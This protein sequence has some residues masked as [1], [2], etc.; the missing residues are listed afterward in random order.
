M[1]A[2][3][4]D[5]ADS[6]E[7]DSGQ[8]AMKIAGAVFS[9]SK[10][11]GEKYGAAIV[12]ALVILGL[13]Y[14]WLV[15]L[16]KPVAVTVVLAEADSNSVISGAT[17]EADY[18]ASPYI[19]TAVKTNRAVPGSEGRYV[20]SSVPSNTEGIALRVK[21]SGEYESYEGLISTED[22]SKTV[23]VKM[24]KKTQLHIEGGKVLGS[25]A[26][27]CTKSFNVPIY[28]NDT[29][30]DVA[31]ELLAEKDALPNFRA[32]KR[33]IAAGETANVTFTITTNYPDSDK[34]PAFIFGDVRISGTK[35]T[36]VANITLTKKTEL[37]HDPSEIKLKIGNTQLVEIK[38]N[39]KGRITG[40]HVALDDYSRKL[41]DMVG[42]QENEEF[43]LESGQTKT[44]YTTGVAEGIGILTIS[45]DCTAPQEIPVKITAD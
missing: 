1:P 15:V 44:A 42:L 36:V 11:I 30:N 20:F 23:A 7:E 43:D 6:E 32:D 18:L 22:S 4:L 13:L 9:Q 29:E 5:E 8:N 38:N 24:F 31:V 10:D 45:A 27:S 37:A 39:G 35:A 12:A 26:P 25:I 2:P 17:V 28:N 19:F 34:N 14:F 33:T 3:R 41:I 21:K 40:V 16:P